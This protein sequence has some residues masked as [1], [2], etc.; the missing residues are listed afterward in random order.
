MG[1][2]ARVSFYIE[3]HY[4]NSLIETLAA[5]AADLRGRRAMSAC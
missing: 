4:E 1:L 2:S 5:S 3:I